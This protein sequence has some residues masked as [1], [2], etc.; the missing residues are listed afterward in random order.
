[1]ATPMTDPAPNSADEHEI[2]RQAEALYAGLQAAVRAVDHADLRLLHELHDL[3]E[4]EVM[5][6][7][8]NRHRKRL[9]RAL[10]EY[11][12]ERGH[13]RERQAGAARAPDEAVAN[14]IRLLLE[15][16]RHL[17]GD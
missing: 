12:E 13:A 17:L 4:V 16:G 1:M 2:R 15:R 7:H 14:R 5:I 3:L 11:C 8:A 10:C 9:L 6:E